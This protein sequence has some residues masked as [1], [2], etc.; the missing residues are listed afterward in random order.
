M[1]IALIIEYNEGKKKDIT[2]PDN[3]DMTKNLT[4]HTPQF[5][6]SFQEYKGRTKT[7]I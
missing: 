1:T 4:L 3:T 5:H 6:P 7:M 2:M